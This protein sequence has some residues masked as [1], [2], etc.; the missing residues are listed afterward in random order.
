MAEEPFTGCLS[1]LSVGI[2]GRTKDYDGSRSSVGSVENPLAASFRAELGCD[3]EEAALLANAARVVVAREL[4]LHEDTDEDLV[5]RLRDPRVFGIFAESLVGDR[6]L[7]TTTR[8]ALS[9]HVFDLLPLPLREGDVIL[10]ERRAP[11][12]LLALAVVLVEAGAFT[13]LHFL[14]LVYAVFLDRTLITNVDRATRSDLLQHILGEGEFGEPLR[15]FYACLHLATVSE[16]EA[17]REFRRLLKSRSIA[18]SFKTPLARVTVAKDGGATEL[19]RIAREEGLFPMDVDDVR[20][21]AVLA[22]IPRLPE[23][24]RPL[25]RRWLNR[26]S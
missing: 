3:G 20:S 4:I 13:A 11:P 22:N 25:G 9:E 14:H 10:V 26:S 12:G 5:V 16:P 17:H 7:R 24:L 23:S 6:R 1:A 8:V 2:P 21:P 19:V 18:D 15:T